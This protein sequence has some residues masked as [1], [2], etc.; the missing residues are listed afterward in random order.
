MAK[1]NYNQQ[2]YGS[3]FKLI[4]YLGYLTKE[5]ISV[6][7]EGVVQR[8]IPS[9]RV[10]ISD[11]F[12]RNFECV[13]CGRCCQGKFS[14][15]YTSSDFLGR[16]PLKLLSTQ[17]DFEDSEMLRKPSFLCIKRSERDEVY[18]LLFSGLKKIPIQI[19]KKVYADKQCERIEIL[20][21]YDKMFLYS[22]EGK[23]CKFLFEKDKKWLC[24]IHELNPTHCKLPHIQIDKTKNSTRLIKRQ[25]GRNWALGCKAKCTS[26]NYKVFCEWDLACLKRLEAN[27]NDLQLKTW[28]PEIIA[29]L[30]SNKEK[31]SKGI[32]PSKP[33]IIY[34]KQRNIPA[35]YIV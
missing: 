29:Y 8:Y 3:V 28:L 16:D 19:S 24:G 1:I 31:F 10:M 20:S 7:I 9:D 25:Y 22:N 21:L 33:V 6:E 5:P 23:R 35:G 14:L 12:F 18:D 2:T 30:E 27:M 34:D 4:K 11:K 13:S 15:A 26:F 17:N 32:L